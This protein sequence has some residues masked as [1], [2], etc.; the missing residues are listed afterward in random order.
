M[1]LYRTREKFLV[2]SIW[3]WGYWIIGLV[4]IVCGIALV[5]TARKLGIMSKTLGFVS[6]C[7]MLAGLILFLVGPIEMVEGDKE[8]KTF[9]FKKISLTGSKTVVLKWKQIK[10]VDIA[11]AGKL[12]SYNNTI[13]Y[14]I[15]FQTTSNNQVKCLETTN[16]KK[17][18]E[19]V[20]L[21]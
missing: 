1:N 17:A 11:M 2:L 20:S 5:V 3:P 14:R 7:M 12:D 16:R 4:A 8:A 9:A 21:V 6:I 15:E 10:D 13:H 18:K 19:R